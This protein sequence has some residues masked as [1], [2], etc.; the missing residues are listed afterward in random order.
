MKRIIRLTIEILF[1]CVG[2]RQ[3]HCN[4]WLQALQLLV[5][6]PDVEL[7]LITK[8]LL[9]SLSSQCLASKSGDTSCCVL[10]DDEISVLVDRLSTKHPE[11]FPKLSVQVLLKL[12]EH[13]VKIAENVSLFLQRGILALLTKLSDGLICEDEKRILARVLWRLMQYKNEGEG[14]LKDTIAASDTTESTRQLGTIA[15][16]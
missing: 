11:P 8:A 10:K 15:L 9:S 13:L 4:N 2:D 12:M 14:D 16:A 7:R 3:S 6:A 1:K 5:H